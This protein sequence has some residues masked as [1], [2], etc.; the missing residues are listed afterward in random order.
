MAPGRFV[1][2]HSMI[3]LEANGL[4][5]LK[6]GVGG[7]SVEGSILPF[8]NQLYAIA[9]DVTS[10]A[11]LFGIFNGVSG[12]RAEVVDGLVLAPA[13]DAARTPT[14]HAIVYERVADLSGDR[15]ADDARFAALTRLDP[16]APEGSIPPDLRDHLLGNFGPREAA[17]GGDMLLSLPLTRSLA[18]GLGYSEGKGD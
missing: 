12:P 14:S 11:L 1:H 7:M 10:G 6:I 2:D 8:G 9:V 18:R 13:Q 15:D 16:V 4:L 17:Q 5:S 3:R